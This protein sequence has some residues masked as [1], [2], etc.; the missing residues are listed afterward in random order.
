MIRKKFAVD[1]VTSPWVDHYAT[2]LTTSWFVGKYSS[3]PACWLFY[4]YSFIIIHW[5]HMIQ[6]KAQN[7]KN[8]LW[9]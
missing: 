1:E 3:K 9:K 7:Y 8:M 2:W 6:L 4:V 5:M